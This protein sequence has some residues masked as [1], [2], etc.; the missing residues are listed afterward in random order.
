M[1][2][3]TADNGS[4]ANDACYQAGP[5]SKDDLYYEDD[6]CYEHDLCYEDDTYCADDLCDGEDPYCADDGYYEDDLYCTDDMCHE[7]HPCTEGV[8]YCE[9]D[10]HDT[11]PIS[12]LLAEMIKPLA[13][14][15]KQA[16]P[17]AEGLDNY[18]IS[19]ITKVILRISI[20]LGEP[21]LPLSYCTC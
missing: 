19:F 21:S 12:E 5:H 14:D 3:W 4:P 6:L 17:A 2:I 8:D 18:G 16:T 15:S 7:K 13:A 20:P 9:G 1:H 10:L 11:D